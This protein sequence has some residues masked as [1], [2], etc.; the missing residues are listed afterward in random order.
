MGQAASLFQLW[1]LVRAYTARL[2]PLPCSAASRR[3]LSA[4]RDEAS[5][6]PAVLAVSGPGEPVPVEPR[7]RSAVGAPRVRRHVPRVRGRER[8]RRATE[9]ET[10]DWR[11][12]E[13]RDMCGEFRAARTGRHAAMLKAGDGR[14]HTVSDGRRCLVSACR[15]VR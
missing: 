13:L 6:R 2:S 12:C 14:R 10:G 1:Q 9:R 3:V 4:V 15:P 11:G 5:R 8:C 7:G